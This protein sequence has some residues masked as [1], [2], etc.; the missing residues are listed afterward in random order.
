M[1]INK[2]TGNEPLFVCQPGCLVTAGCRHGDTNQPS[3]RNDLRVSS[4]G[5]GFQL[6]EPSENQAVFGTGVT[7]LI[8]SAV[9]LS[10]SYW[11]PKGLSHLYLRGSPGHGGGH[12]VCKSVFNMNV[13]V[14][15]VVK[16][17]RNMACTHSFL[18]TGEYRRVIE[19]NGLKNHQPV[20]LLR[21]GQLYK[22]PQLHGF[23]SWHSS[24]K[25]RLL[26]CGL[27]GERQITANSAGI[28]GLQWLMPVS[29]CL[30]PLRAEPVNTLVPLYSFI[31][32]SSL[33]KC[34]LSFY[35]D[36]VPC[37]A[38]CWMLGRE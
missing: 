2:T 33:P 26:S 16:S 24:R 23:P 4:S 30:A 3:S 15:F 38:A 6:W 25:L 12:E 8:R 7:G 22:C 19:G 1:P 37:Q 35:W 27:S 21:V 28:W 32:L 5:G 14:A 34:I 13:P 10:V 29:V 20:L 11:V 18:Y 17:I 36:Q 9:S 31:H